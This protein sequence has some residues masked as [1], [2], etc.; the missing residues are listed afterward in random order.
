M[1]EKCS[2]KHDKKKKVYEGRKPPTGTLYVKN[3]SI[4]DSPANRYDTKL[5]MK[6]LKAAGAKK[7][8]T[9]NAYGW[10]NQPEV[11]LFSGLDEKAAQ[12]ALDDLPVFKKWGAL[13][14][15]AHRDW[16]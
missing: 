14:F 10:S 8:W 16:E 12:L 3:S 5:F 11:V 15:D 2:G 6:T 4:F 1:E 7:V 9:D 13:I